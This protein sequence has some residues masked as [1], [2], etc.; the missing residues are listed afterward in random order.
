MYHLLMIRLS[1]KYRQFPEYKLIAVQY[2]LSQMRVLRN[3]FA[4]YN[5]SDDLDVD[6][7]GKCIH[8]ANRPII[9]QWAEIIMEYSM[10][11]LHFLCLL[12]TLTFT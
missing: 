11:H 7:M 3:D 1:I 6:E 4:K 10:F 8:H 9:K 2:C 12:D 5:L